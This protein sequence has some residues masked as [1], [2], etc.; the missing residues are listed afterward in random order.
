[1][2]GLVAP[3]L[4]D[5]ALHLAYGVLVLLVLSWIAYFL[6]HPAKS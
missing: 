5:S 1:V 6:A 2:S 4:F 3:L